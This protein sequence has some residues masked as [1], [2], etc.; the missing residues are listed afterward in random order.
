MKLGLVACL[1]VACWAAVGAV[2]DE[3]VIFIG[4]YFVAFNDTSPNAAWV[5]TPVDVMQNATNQPLL[6]SAFSYVPGERVA[7]ISIFEDVDRPI[8]L[9]DE[10]VK[11]RVGEKRIN[12]FDR[13]IAGYPGVVGISENESTKDLLIRA[14]FTFSSPVWCHESETTDPLV[15]VLVVI[16]TLNYTEAETVRLLDTFEIGRYLNPRSNT[17]TGFS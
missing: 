13:P 12:G 7:S 3:T 5:A 11:P 4:P 17:W 8:D 9:R 1:L 10:I 15:D 16:N 14:A 6:F 2:G